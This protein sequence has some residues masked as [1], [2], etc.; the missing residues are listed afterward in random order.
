MKDNIDRS[1]R[2]TIGLVVVSMTAMLFS[3]FALVMALLTG[4]LA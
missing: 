1:Y 2:I 4:E 3:L